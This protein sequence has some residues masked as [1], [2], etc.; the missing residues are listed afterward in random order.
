LTITLT[1]TVTIALALVF[2]GLVRLMWGDI[3]QRH[4]DSLQYA[5]HHLSQEWKGLSSLHEEEEDFPSLIFTVYTADGKLLTSSTRN[6]I[7]YTS[8]NKM[9]EKGLTFGL[10]HKGLRFVGSDRLAPLSEELRRFASVLAYLLLPLALLMAIATW[11]G[12]GMVLSPIHDLIQSADSLST[13]SKGQLL[14]TRDRREA[15]TV[16]Q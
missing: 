7:P 2:A 8:G 9:D 13:K 14:E 12:G 4:T 15:R 11:L 16:R 6:P 5:V 3:I 1:V 10:E